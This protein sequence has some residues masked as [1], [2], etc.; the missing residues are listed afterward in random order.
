MFRVRPIVIALAFAS[1]MSTA[2]DTARTVAPMD[3][4]PAANTAAGA[5]QRLAWALNHR[6]VELIRGLLSDEF[7]FQ[8]AGLDSAGNPARDTTL[9]RDSLLAVL[10]SLLGGRPGVP[11]PASVRLSLD[12]DLVAFPDTRVG[13]DP[14]VHKTIRTSVDLVVVDSTAQ[15]TFKA[16]GHALFFLSRGD[17]AT[18]PTELKALGAKAD[19][20]RWWIDQWED[21]T[22]GGGGANASLVTVKSPRAIFRFYRDRVKP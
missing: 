21:E 10:R 7:S 1:A 14:R 9:T 6:D 13:R 15:H 4:A 18:I 11:P 20:T 17:S 16:S 2:C 8:T 19:S 5:V 12:A 22:I 3:V